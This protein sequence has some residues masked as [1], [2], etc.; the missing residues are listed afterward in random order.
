M[1]Y[2]L[3]AI[4]IVVDVMAMIQSN[5][6]WRDNALKNDIERL[7]DSYFIILVFTRKV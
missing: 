2:T 5:R 1:I 7:R 3:N 4:G 6:E